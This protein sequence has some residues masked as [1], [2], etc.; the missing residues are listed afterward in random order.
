MFEFVY[1]SIYTVVPGLG[2]DNGSTAQY[3]APDSGRQAFS[4]QRK[5][6]M[7]RL[8]CKPISHQPVIDGIVATVMLEIGYGD[9]C[10]E[11]PVVISAVGS[12]VDQA[13][14]RVMRNGRSK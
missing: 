3:L 10:T 6:F 13:H 5:H 7:A 14:I 9:S 11:N 12:C 4:G 2:C 1:I 8:H